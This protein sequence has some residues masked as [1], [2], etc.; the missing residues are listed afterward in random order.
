MMPVLQLAAITSLALVRASFAGPRAE[1]W[2]TYNLREVMLQA[3]G[4]W[5]LVRQWRN[6]EFELKSSDGI[7]LMTALWWCPDEP[8]LGYEYIVAACEVVI[9]GA[10]HTFRTNKRIRIGPVGGETEIQMAGLGNHADWKK[11][12]DEKLVYSEKY[13]DGTTVQDAMIDETLKRRASWLRDDLL[14]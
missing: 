9:A 2:R 1:G 7:H 3:P 8:L 4:D 11:F 14:D 12:L 6:S 13:P 5:T 10:G